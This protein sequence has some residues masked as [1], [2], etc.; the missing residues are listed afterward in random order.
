MEEV[1]GG[2]RVKGVVRDLDT[3][4]SLLSY[5]EINMRESADSWRAAAM[6][7]QGLNQPMSSK[8]VAW[9]SAMR[10]G[11]A[12]SDSVSSVWLAFWPSRSSFIAAEMS[13]ASVA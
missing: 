8:A 5:H 7:S 3:R 10:A 12:A 6:S 11:A 2:F 1:R 13:A 4:Y 9:A